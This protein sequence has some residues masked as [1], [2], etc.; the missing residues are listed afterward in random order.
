M[1]RITSRHDIGFA[2]HPA[3][4]SGHGACVRSAGRRFG[5]LPLEIWCRA[6]NPRDAERMIPAQ[7]FRKKRGG[8]AACMPVTPRR[9]G[10]PRPFA[11]TRRP[12]RIDVHVFFTTPATT[13]FP[14]TPASPWAKACLPSDRERA[15]IH[16]DQA[17]GPG[18]RSSRQAEPIF[19]K[20]R[21]KDVLHLVF[22]VVYAKRGYTIRYIRNVEEGCPMSSDSMLRPERSP[23]GGCLDAPAGHD[24]VPPMKTDM[25]QP[26]RSRSCPETRPGP[27]M[28]PTRP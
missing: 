11:F 2:A 15:A 8:P 10:A 5:Q 7:D 4:A 9:T 26:G 25:P 17:H 18:R 3:K 22:V 1:D 28:D 21:A 16:P 20:C 19:A 13:R 6:E 27:M 14:F 23:Q 24:L 12:R